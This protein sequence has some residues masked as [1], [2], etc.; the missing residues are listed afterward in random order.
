MP[1]KPPSTRTSVH[2]RK[3][4]RTFCVSFT[5]SEGY[6]QRRFSWFL[7]AL[8]YWWAAKQEPLYDNVKWEIN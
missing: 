4:A 5:S 6:T 3:N 7:Q 1:K 8:G 2:A